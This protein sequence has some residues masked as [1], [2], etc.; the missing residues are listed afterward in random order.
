VLLVIL[1]KGEIMLHFF[2][3]NNFAF[4][5]DKVINFNKDEED[6]TKLIITYW[7]GSS[8]VIKCV[9]EEERDLFFNAMF[10]Y[11]SGTN[12]SVNE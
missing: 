7:I 1:T 10:A 6:N 3:I 9:N 11:V 5:M 2:K 4:N 8:T 12:E